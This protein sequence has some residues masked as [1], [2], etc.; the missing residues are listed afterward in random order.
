MPFSHHGDDDQK[1]GIKAKRIIFYGVLLLILFLIGSPF[2]F[3]WIVNLPPVKT[4]VAAFLYEKTHQ[5]VHLEDFTLGIF[6]HPEL[7]LKNISY[8]PASS[9]KPLQAALLTVQFNALKLLNGQLVVDQVIISNPKIDPSFFRLSMASSE[10]RLPAPDLSNIDFLFNLLPKTQDAVEIFIKNFTTPYFTKMDGTLSVSR[11]HSKIV[12]DLTLLG[13]N[14]TASDF[15]PGPDPPIRFENF[16]AEKLTLLSVIKPGSGITGHA[17]FKMVRLYKDKTQP[18]FRTDEVKTEFSVKS[19]EYNVAVTPFRARY[20]D[21]VLETRFHSSSRDK[22]SMLRFTGSDINI[23]QVRQSALHLFGKQ[24]VTRTLFDIIRDG[25]SPRIEVEFNH[26]DL[27]GLLDENN[28][29]LSGRIQNGTVKIPETHLVARNVDGKAALSSGVLAIETSHGKIGQSII[30]QGRLNIDLLNYADVPFTG[31][32]GLDVALPE[33][34]DTLIKLLPGTLLAEELGL[35]DNITGRASAVLT[36]DYPPGSDNLDVTVKTQQFAA[37]GQYGRIPGPIQ[38]DSVIFDYRPGQIEV[39]NLTGTIHGNTIQNLHTKVQLNDKLSIDIIE[40][41]ADIYLSNTLSWLSAYQKPQKMMHPVVGGTGLLK[42][43]RL[44]VSGPVTEPEQWRFN[45]SGSGKNVSLTTHA[46]QKEIKDLSLD[47]AVKNDAYFL[48]NIKF[49]ALNFNWLKPYANQGMID[50]IAFPVSATDGKLMVSEKKAQFHSNLIF[51]GNAT[52][53]INLEGTS[54]AAMVPRHIHLNDSGLS[55]ASLKI[56]PAKQPRGLDFA[57]KLNT[58][59]LR[60]VLNP[61][62]S[63]A[64]FADQLSRSAPLIIEKKASSDYMVSTTAFGLDTLLELLKHS[65]DRETAFPSAVIRFQA[66]RVHYKKL[67]FTDVAS[68]IQLSPDDVYIRLHRAALC[69]LD[70]KAYFT[71]KDNRL[72]ASI[73]FHAVKTD[74][75]QDLLT[76]LVDRDNFMDGQYSFDGNLIA[77]TPPHEFSRQLNGNAA[78]SAIDG[79]IYKLTLLSRILSVLNVSKVFRGKI[80]D[81]TQKGFAYNEIVIESDI[82]N[83]LIKLKKAVIDGKDMTLIFEGSI[84]PVNDAV[85]LNCLVAPFKTVD[86][87]IEKIPIINTLFSGRLVSVPVKITGKLSDPVVVPLHPSAVGTGLINMMT[88]IVKTPVRLFDKLANEKDKPEN[89]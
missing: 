9:P 35:V 56:S 64:L 7:G 54:F 28:L 63:W 20:P 57:G 19:G 81:I 5:Q 52:A 89:E 48:D 74:N 65:T 6:P 46:G 25:S 69:D 33:I 55:D 50:Q 23:S 83:S 85:N 62:G 75:I 86:M 8:T 22:N 24:A 42:L 16:N 39:R 61:K 30:E 67:Q 1:M 45:I 12:C 18:L 14:L 27:Q 66:D 11:A 2:F 3:P 38:L 29:S 37:T 49:T 10:K 88:D 43:S 17:S 31:E 51:T 76:C 82:E 41:A 87:I 34:P 84:D 4:R 59:T 26:P 80:P 72:T 44:T 47:F 21:A 13:L 79:R 70:T 53:S 71:L 77:D 60:K 40:G 73:P 58:A 78:F 68:R 36:L 32:F 15:F